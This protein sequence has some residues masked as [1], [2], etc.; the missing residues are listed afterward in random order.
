MSIFELNNTN[1][2]LDSE[3]FYLDYLNNF[4]TVDRIA[5]HY[6]ITPRQARILIEVG[7][8]QNQVRNGVRNIREEIRNLIFKK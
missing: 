3:N 8:E 6:A 5:E 4:L 2:I 1:R 7:R